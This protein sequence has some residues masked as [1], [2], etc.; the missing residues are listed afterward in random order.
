MSSI[1]NILLDIP[2]SKQYIRLSISSH[3]GEFFF[4]TIIITMVVRRYRD[5]F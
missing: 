1:M 3:P 5:F 2:T 4:F